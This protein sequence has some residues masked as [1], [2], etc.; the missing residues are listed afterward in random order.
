VAIWSIGAVAAPVRAASERTV[1]ASQT[2]FRELWGELVDG[3]RF[4]F[5]HPILRG[6]VLSLAVIHLGL[7]P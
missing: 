5:G 4:L 3:L 2:C 7:V 6:V 1:R